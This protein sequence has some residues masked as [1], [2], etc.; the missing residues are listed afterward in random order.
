MFSGTSLVR[1]GTPQCCVSIRRWPL[2]GT[3]SCRHPGRYRELVS[4]LQLYPSHGLHDLVKALKQA[5]AINS[6][7]LLTVEAFLGSRIEPSTGLGGRLTD[8]K[9]R[10][11]ELLA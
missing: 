2:L 7:S 5:A 11:P 1:Y 9:V 10:R 4:I 8:L 3:N 6:Y